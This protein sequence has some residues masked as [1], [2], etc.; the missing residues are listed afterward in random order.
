MLAK[1]WYLLII[2]DNSRLSGLPRFVVK[3]TIVMADSSLLGGAPEHNTNRVV[4]A[5]DKLVP[6][7]FAVFDAGVG[8][9]EFFRGVAGDDENFYPLRQR[10]MVRQSLVIS[11][12]LDSYTRYSRCSLARSASLRS[13]CATVL[14]LV[15]SHPRPP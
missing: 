10:L 9:L 11:G 5:I 2:R 15:L 14:A 6:G 13:R 3:S 7:P 4:G 12:W 8:D 1:R